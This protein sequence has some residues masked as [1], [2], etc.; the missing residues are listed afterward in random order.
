VVTAVTLKET[1]DRLVHVQCHRKYW[2]GEIWTGPALQVKSFTYQDNWKGET[3]T[4]RFHI[5]QTDL[6]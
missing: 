6:S 3:I 4:P 5:K 1:S 2:K